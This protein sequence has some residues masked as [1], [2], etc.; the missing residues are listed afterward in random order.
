M[1][2]NTALAEEFNPPP[3][4]SNSAVEKFSMTLVEEE[5]LPNYYQNSLR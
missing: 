2:N 3:P 5:L 4:S 1:N